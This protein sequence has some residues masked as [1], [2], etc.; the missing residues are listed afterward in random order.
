MYFYCVAIREPGENNEDE[1]D[2]IVQ[3][4][5]YV[6]DGRKY[7]K[8]VMHGYVDQTLKGDVSD[9]RDTDHPFPVTFTITGT[10]LDI[11]G[12][13]VQ[14][15]VIISRVFNWSQAV[16]AGFGIIPPVVVT[17]SEGAK[18]SDVTFKFM[19]HLN[20]VDQHAKQFAYTVWFRVESGPA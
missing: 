12:S 4:G 20:D 1:R 14:G 10:A 6:R 11:D 2:N 18:G 3:L 13:D 7:N 17:V 5:Q 19:I 15:Q 9:V 8:Y 16:N